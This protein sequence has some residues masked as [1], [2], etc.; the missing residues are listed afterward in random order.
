MHEAMQEGK[1]MIVML[2]W[3]D[4]SDLKKGPFHLFEAFKLHGFNNK[5]KSYMHHTSTFLHL[6]QQGIIEALYNTHIDK[7][8][9]SLNFMQRGQAM[10]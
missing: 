4:G 3:R 2:K 1:P 8:N 6:V 9:I 10:T 7:H 5:Y